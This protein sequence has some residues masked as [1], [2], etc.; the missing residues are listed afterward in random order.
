MVLCVIAVGIGQPQISNAVPVSGPIKAL[1]P[2]AQICMLSWVSMADQ[3]LCLEIGS[4]SRQ[5]EKAIQ[6][7]Q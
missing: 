7:E 4:G 3:K 6:T 1:I 2:S 5:S